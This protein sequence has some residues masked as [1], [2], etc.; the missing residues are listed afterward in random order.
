MLIIDKVHSTYKELFTIKLVHPGFELTYPYL[1]HVSH[2]PKTLTISSIF[3]VLSFEPD[4]AT[5]NLFAGCSIDFRCGN[6][7]VI[8]YTRSN[9]QKPYIMLPHD[10]SLRFM[11]QVQTSFISKTDVVAAGSSK[12]YQFTNVDRSG[13]VGNRFINKVATGVNVT[14]DLKN[15]SDL[16]PEKSC[17]AVVDIHTTLADPVY[18]LFDAGDLQGPDYTIIFNKK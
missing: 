3:S 7:M 1:H 15:V 2:N 12:V 5:Q 6:N 16:A 9:A 14:D 4:T 13:T 11:I 10:S 17:F 18:G 8:C